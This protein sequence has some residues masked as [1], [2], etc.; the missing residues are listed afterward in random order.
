MIRK[1]RL[2][3][4][5]I[6]AVTMFAASAFAGEVEVL[7]WWTSGSE[8][9]AI[10]ELQKMLQKEGHSWKD[11]AVAGGAGSNAMTA[12][13]S[14]AVSGNPPTAA[15]VKGPQIQDWAE[16]G[17]LANLDDVARAEKWDSM[18]PGVVADIMKYEGHWVAVPVNVHR[19]NWMWINPAVFKKAGARIPTTADEF[20]DACEKIR[21]AGMTPIAWGGQAWQE[22]TAFESLVA[23]V[24]GNDFYRKAMIEADEKALASDTMVK[25][26]EMFGRMKQYTDKNAPGRDWNLATAMVIKGEAGVQ[27]MGDWAK[28]EFTAANMEPGKDYLA[29]PVFGTDDAFLFNVD[30]FIM[31]RVSDPDAQAAQKAMARLILSPD[32]QIVF[33]VNKGSIPVRSGI[34]EDAFDA[35]AR[36]AIKAFEAT[37]RSGGLMPSMAHEMAVSPAVRGAMLDVITN[38]FNSDTSAADG[39]RQLAAAVAEAKM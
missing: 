14:R 29:V 37:A 8:S 12:L 35:V 30:S 1:L 17:V 11:F 7:H 6:A 2:L 39:A 22:A 38:F 15:Q 20:F 21:Q 5:A 9:A 27:F 34:P 13:K 28:G 24:G 16:L 32:F 26:F 33:N 19:I 10:Q 18:V 23:S 4:A 25:V 31:F 3:L 36:D